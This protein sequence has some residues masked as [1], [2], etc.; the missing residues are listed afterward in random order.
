MAE[1]EAHRLFRETGIIGWVAN[2]PLTIRGRVLH[3]DVA[4][5]RQKIAFEVN[6]FEYHSSRNEMERDAERMNLL[7][8]A[9][10][11]VYVLTPSAIRNAPTETA[12]FI[13]RVLPPACR[14]GV[15]GPGR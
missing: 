3:P 1:V 14:R 5:L 15:G 4:F 8:E 11:K 12:E 6:G 7:I 2:P 13:Q 9:G 10:W